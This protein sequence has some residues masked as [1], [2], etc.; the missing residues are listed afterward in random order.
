MLKRI[1]WTLL[2]FALSTSADED[3][4]SVDRVIP[5]SIDFAFPN[6]SSIQPEPSD[7]TVKNFVL[8]SNDAGGRWAVVTITN[9][10]SGSRSLTHK[11]LMAVVANGQR[12]SPIEFLQSFRANETLS[13]TISFG[14]RKFP[15]LLVYSRTKD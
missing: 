6:E 10:A 13:L 7:F 12:V 15:L 4:L 2:F 1:S 8:M 3:I 9:E 5:N 14:R 11:H